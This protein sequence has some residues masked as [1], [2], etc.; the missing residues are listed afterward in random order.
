ME[1]LKY[2]F[3]CVLD[4]NTR[5][6]WKKEKCLIVKSWNLILQVRWSRNNKKFYCYLRGN[7]SKLIYSGRNILKVYKFI[8]LAINN[9][10]YMDIEY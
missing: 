7:K 9:N 6:R 10:L 4:K 2:L 8:N 1:T 3:D 5:R